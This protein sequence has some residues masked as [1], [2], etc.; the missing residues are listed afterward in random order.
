MLGR[1]R[2]NVDD[3]IRDYE[4][5]GEKVFGHPRLFHLRSPLFWVRD[6]YDHKILE[7]V[8]KEVIENRVPHVPNFPGG[9]NFAF[10][11]NRCRT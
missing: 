2:M 8:I 1:L 9:R 10:D 6:K 3:C 4:Q 7:K 5:F 11:E